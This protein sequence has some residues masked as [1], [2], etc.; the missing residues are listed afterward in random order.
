MIKTPNEHQEFFTKQRYEG[1]LAKSLP[2][3]AVHDTQT[4]QTQF[5]TQNQL[6]VISY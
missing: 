6:F 3:T 5:H 4:V 2:S 1:G